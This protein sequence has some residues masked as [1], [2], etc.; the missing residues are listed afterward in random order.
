MEDVNRVMAFDSFL[1][2]WNNTNRKL[3]ELLRLLD[4]DSLYK[5][6]SFKDELFALNQKI[7][8]H[9]FL[10]FKSVSDDEYESWRAPFF[11][12]LSDFVN[13]VD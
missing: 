12:E 6:I 9:T 4:D 8:G 11:E 7:I 13:R 10:C 1:I 3:D 2:N 5:H